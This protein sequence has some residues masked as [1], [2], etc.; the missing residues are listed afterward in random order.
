M[1]SAKLEL[2]RPACSGGGERRERPAAREDPTSCSRRS[3]AELFIRDCLHHILDS[4][5]GLQIDIETGLK[6][7]KV[8][9]MSDDSGEE[10]PSVAGNGKLSQEYAGATGTDASLEMQIHMQEVTQLRDELVRL[11]EET[12]ARRANANDNGMFTRSYI[13]VPRECQVQPFSG[14]CGADGRSGEEFIEEAERALRSREQTTDEQCDY[15]LSLLCGPA[16]EEVRL[17]MRGPTVTPRD[18]YSYLRNAFGERRST[19]QL[20][21]NFYNRKQTDGEDLRDYSHA[22]SQILSSVVKQS[23]NA[24]P[25]EKI[26]LRDQFIEGLRDSA[27]R[28]EPRKMVRDKPDSSLLDVRNE[29]FLWEMEENRSHRTRV[30]KSSQVKYEVSETQCSA[31]ETDH[32]QSSVLSDV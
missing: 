10:G 31:V 19:T 14:E 30:V 12:R 2:E 32:G 8:F 29:A 9:I 28:C 27:L 20:L 16:L 23:S 1:K 5:I 25:N 4:R 17:C 3:Q 18:L 11:N 24:I 22:L 13:Y 15:I 6:G 26:V 21:Q 7:K